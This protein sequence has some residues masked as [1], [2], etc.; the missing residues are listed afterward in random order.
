MSP[1]AISFNKAFSIKEI[2][3]IIN[4]GVSREVNRISETV[5]LLLCTCDDPATNVNIGGYTSW[6]GIMLQ[7][8]DVLHTNEKLRLLKPDIS[9]I[10]RERDYLAMVYKKALLW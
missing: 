3:E 10:N 9:T 5:L 8:F 2:G 4:S 6:S 1:Q 7:S